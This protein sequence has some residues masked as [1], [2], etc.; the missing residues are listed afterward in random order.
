MALDVGRDFQ[1]RW[2]STPEA[3]RQQIFSEL[4]SIC[5]LL[6]PVTRFEEWQVADQARHEQQQA[7]VDEALEEQRLHEQ[8]RIA[9]EQQ[10]AERQQLATQHKQATAIRTAFSTSSP[11]SSTADQSIP[12]Q[13]HSSD[14]SS[15]EQLRQRLITDVEE[16]IEQLLQ[17]QKQ[18]LT[19][20]ATQEI[21]RLLHHKAG[22]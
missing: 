19:A 20:W 6:E 21:D 11:V 14:L 4:N 18:Q 7:L 22:N 12:E 3:V 1:K 17:Q 5:K 13:L 16:H 10:L 15:A 2:H 9:A 8:A